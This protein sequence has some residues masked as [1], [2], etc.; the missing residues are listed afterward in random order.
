MVEV[1]ILVS[2]RHNF[3]PFT[4]VVWDCLIVGLLWLH[5][6]QSLANVTMETIACG[7]L[8]GRNDIKAGM[9]PWQPEQVVYCRAK[10]F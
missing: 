9:L 6:L 8:Y 2:R 1:R 4:A 3:Q 7:L 10:P 5:H